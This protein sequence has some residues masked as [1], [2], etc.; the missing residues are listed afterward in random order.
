MEVEKSKG[1][2][3]L[4]EGVWDHLLFWAIKG[5][6]GGVVGGPPCRTTSR[7]R[8]FLDG[9]PVPGRDRSEGRWGIAGLDGEMQRWFRRIMFSGCGFC[10]FMQ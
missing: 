2:D 8:N 7:C 5:V 3:L 6:L 1:C 9:G 10:S 4:G